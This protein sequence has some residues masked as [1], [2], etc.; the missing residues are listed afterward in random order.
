MCSPQKS[1]QKEGGLV[2]GHEGC[3]GHFFCRVTEIAPLRPL[4]PPC[5]E[6]VWLAGVLVTMLP[7]GGMLGE[8]R[9]ALGSVR[10]DT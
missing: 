1:A 5:Q 8:L 3:L 7:W 4:F 6:L 9:C 2:L 10:Q